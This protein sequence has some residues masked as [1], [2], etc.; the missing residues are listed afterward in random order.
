MAAARC[1]FRISRR[2]VLA[3]TATATAAVTAPLIAPSRLLAQTPAATSAASPTATGPQLYVSA[4]NVQFDD[5]F[6]IGVSGLDPFQEVEI[7][8]SYVDAAGKDWTAEGT[9][10]ADSCGFF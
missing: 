10:V 5:A 6:E 2:R 9:S 3:A 8:S 1:L 4:T 7:S